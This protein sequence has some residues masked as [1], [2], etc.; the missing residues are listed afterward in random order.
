VGRAGVPYR[1]RRAT[2]LVVLL[3]TVEQ[4]SAPVPV[5]AATPVAPPWPVDDASAFAVRLSALSPRMALAPCWAVPLPAQLRNAREPRVVTFLAGRYCAEQAL[6]AAGVI[7]RPTIHFGPDRE[8][9]W[10][11]GYIGS[12]THT[13]YWAGAVVARK[14]GIASIGIDTEELLSEAQA[15]D[16][17]RTV[18]PEYS[19]INFVGL[20]ADGVRDASLVSC[21]FSAKESIYKCLHPLVREFFEFS[22]VSVTK[23]DRMRGTIHTVLNRPLGMFPRHWPLDVRFAMADGRVHTSLVLRANEIPSERISISGTVNESST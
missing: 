13:A 15:Q 16:V 5:I 7:G 23:V 17:G 1:L 20:D 18:A 10:P 12:I 6:R 14:N 8:P 2:K 11:D 4:G 19:G 21:L 9:I 3:A 22:D